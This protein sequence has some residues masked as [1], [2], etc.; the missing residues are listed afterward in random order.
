MSKYN[1]VRTVVD[2]ITFASKAEARRYQELKMMELSGD[3]TQLELQPKFPLIVNG[4]K[5]GTYIGDFRYR[6]GAVVYVEDVKGMKTP[7][8]NL[9][10]KMMK[11]Q[12]NIEIYET[13]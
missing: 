10:K 2:G 7:V 6:Y 12:Y 3:I 9:K 8:Y 13:E 4:V 5:V 1:A 11:A